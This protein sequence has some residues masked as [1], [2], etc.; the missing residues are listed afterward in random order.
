MA[1]GQMNIPFHSRA[2][3]GYPLV[4]RW[5]FQGEI[6]RPTGKRKEPNLDWLRETSTKNPPQG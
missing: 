4:D 6:I 2:A 3:D 5:R 1:L